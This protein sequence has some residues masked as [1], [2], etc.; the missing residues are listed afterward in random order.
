M[1]STLTFLVLVQDKFR[2][3]SS[4]LRSQAS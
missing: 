3:L 4:P 2:E 1:V